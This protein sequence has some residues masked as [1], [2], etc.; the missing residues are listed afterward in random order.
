MRSAVRT[1]TEARETIS[2]PVRWTQ[3]A[4]ARDKRERTA[5]VDAPHATKWSITG[6]V[7]R[8]SKEPWFNH[9]AY[10]YIYK[11]LEG[12]MPFRFNDHYKNKHSDMMAMFDRAIELAKEDDA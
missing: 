2:D 6:A 9:K 7:E 4:E 11:A 8:Q 5:K 12:V 10:S 3:R 1:L